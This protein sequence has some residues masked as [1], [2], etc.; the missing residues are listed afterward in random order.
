MQNKS[1]L[2]DVA[3]INKTQVYKNADEYFQ[4]K[5]FKKISQLLSV[6][7]ERNGFQE[8]YEEIQN[9]RRHDSIFIDGKRGSGKTVFLLNIEKYL[10]DFDENI[11]KKYHFFNPIDPTLLQD[12]EDFLG[13]ILGT[14]VKELSTKKYLQD[15]NQEKLTSYYKALEDLSHSL[16]A[17]KEISNNELKGIDEIASFKSSNSLE[18]YT[19]KFFY[20]VSRLLGNKKLVLLIDDVDMAFAKGFD[21]LETIRKFLASPYI[22]PIV[23]GDGRLYKEIIKREFR[24]KLSREKSVDKSS[25]EFEDLMNLVDQYFN[26]VMPNDNRIQLQDKE[27]I[28]KDK[29]ISIKHSAGTCDFKEIKDFEEKTIFYGINQKQFIE[30]VFRNNIRSFVQYIAKKSTIYSDLTK[31]PNKESMELTADFYRFVQ[32]ED[33]I[34]KARLSK[35]LDNDV[36]AFIDEKLSVYHIF[37]GDF[38][39]NKNYTKEKDPKTYLLKLDKEHLQD[40]LYLVRDKRDNAGNIVDYLNDEV[41]IA[42]IIPRL[43]TYEDYYTAGTSTRFYIFGGK[44]IEFMMFCCSIENIENKH[45]KIN[46]I[47]NSTPYNTGI[48]KNYLDEN[49]D[50]DSKENEDSNE[51]YPTYINSEDEEVLEKLEKWYEEYSGS[52]KIGTIALHH[53]LNK[54]FNNLNVIKGLSLS[55]NKKGLDVQAMLKNGET[56]V[57]YFKR[58]VVIFLNAVASIEKRGIISNENIANADTKFDFENIQSKSNTF[59]NNISIL[60]EENKNTTTKAFYENPIIQAILYMKDDEKLR[61]PNTTKTSNM[62]KKYANRY[63]LY[64]KYKRANWQNTDDITPEYA[65]QFYNGLMEKGLLKFYEEKLK[66]SRVRFEKRI[67]ELR[68]R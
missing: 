61:F 1:I 43:F 29:D 32:K 34:E 42:Y 48:K 3:N 60:L 28:F 56:P 41:G 31:I 24:Y 13:V 59:R 47:I 7:L 9:S 63:T 55:E 53:I 38:F 10:K 17:V 8:E 16:V 35:M 64:D 52:I 37:K 26:K 2:I 18:D 11:S 19:N 54:F 40:R 65:N 30:D 57:G 39:Q 66:S 68:H 50:G 45:K 51:G 46:E 62:P 14:V 6:E 36:D 5:A 67:E 15:C 25:N 58:I 21:V 49:F 44:F 4:K 22:L 23:S 27:S 20:E 12:S 33:D